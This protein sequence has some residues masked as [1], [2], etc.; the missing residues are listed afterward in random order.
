M[1]EICIPEIGVGN[2]ADSDK[3]R[4]RKQHRLTP[5]LLQLKANSDVPRAMSA[6]REKYRSI[7]AISGTWAGFHFS[8]GSFLSCSLC[9]G[10]EIGYSDWFTGFSVAVGR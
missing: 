7:L 3:R 6:S 10:L 5:F 2:T 1:Y 4:T 9:L 8:R